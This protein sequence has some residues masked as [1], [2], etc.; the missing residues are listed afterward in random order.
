MDILRWVLRG[1]AAPDMLLQE[2]SS[3]LL[4]ITGM[5]DF[6]AWLQRKHDASWH[7][8][9]AVGEHMLPFIARNRR[10]NDLRPTCRWVGAEM[11][12]M[13]A[14]QGGRQSAVSDAWAG[15]TS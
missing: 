1:I 4:R 10:L 9:Q 12:V 7:A 8:L 6:S 3:H 15:K 2:W 13:I 11:M 14:G 5:P